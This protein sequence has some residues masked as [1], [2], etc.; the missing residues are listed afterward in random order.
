MSEHQSPKIPD[1]IAQEVIELAS[2]L[3]AEA[4]Q[5]SEGYSLSELQEIGNEVAIP[6]QIM[7]EAL[8]Q[9][10]EKYRQAESNK[11][12]LKQQLKIISLSALGIA[13]VISLWGILT[14]NSLNNNQQEVEAA[15]AQ[16]E[17]QLQRKADLIPNLINI[18]Q[19]QAEHEK[20]LII[21]LTNARK[22]Y[23]QADTMEEKLASSQNINQVINQ[24]NQY[25]FHNQQLASSQAFTN[26]QYE[27]T[28]TENRIA[29]ERR[30][31]NQ[32]V[33]KYN[34][35]LQS[36]PHSIIADLSGLTP[37][38]FFQSSPLH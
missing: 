27:I 10:K 33:Q 5:N 18:T 34:K 13:I 3:Y 26:L 17:N 19:A 20:Q 16:V 8:T 35:N 15:W 37:A 30:R 22:Q 12:K 21:L 11:Q 24:F 38:S 31:Y 23:L 32:T 1:D 14:Y 9:I 36:F 25:A 28:G 7:K 2:N 4:Q 6:D 29:T